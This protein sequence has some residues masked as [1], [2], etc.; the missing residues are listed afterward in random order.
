ML[1]YIGGLILTIDFSGIFKLINEIY[2]VYR[3]ECMEKMSEKTD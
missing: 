1:F 2:E 3:P